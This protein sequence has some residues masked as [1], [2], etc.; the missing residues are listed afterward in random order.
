MTDRDADALR[1]D[2]ESLGYRQTAA[3]ESIARSLE[4]LATPL[5]WRSGVRA[6]MEAPEGTVEL[7]IDPQRFHPWLL[8]RLGQVHLEN[9]GRPHIQMLEALADAVMEELTRGR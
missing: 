7:A 1:F 8:E 9:L 5:R 6:L 4:A 3:L 2:T